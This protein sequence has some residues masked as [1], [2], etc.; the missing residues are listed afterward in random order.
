MY[1]IWN[2]MTFF[3]D[4]IKMQITQSSS[5]WHGIGSHNIMSYFTRRKAIHELSTYLFRH[6]ANDYWLFYGF[7][8]FLS[9]GKKLKYNIRCDIIYNKLYMFHVHI[10]PVSEKYHVNCCSWEEFSRIYSQYCSWWYF[11]CISSSFHQNTFYCLHF[12]TS[13]PPSQVTLL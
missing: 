12:L 1:I 4:L 2:E 13:Q 8:I 10:I 5:L 9:T 11:C 6:L 7:A 3:G